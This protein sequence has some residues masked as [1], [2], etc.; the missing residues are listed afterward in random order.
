M[1]RQEIK[2][3]SRDSQGE[4]RR[5]RG[6]WRKERGGGG[7]EKGREEGGWRERARET[8]RDRSRERLR[9]T[10]TSRVSTELDVHTRYKDH[11]GGA[12]LL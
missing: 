9:Y 3:V 11:R 5:E 1:D 6:G 8:D 2:I 10:L 12:K 4:K 7:V